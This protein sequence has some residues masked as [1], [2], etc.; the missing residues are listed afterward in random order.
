MTAFLDKKLPFCTRC[1]TKGLNCEY[2]E[3]FFKK[4][5]EKKEKKRRKKKGDI[6]TM[7]NVGDE[8][9]VAANAIKSIK[10]NTIETYC[11]IVCMGNPPFDQ[12][13]CLK[14]NNQII[15]NLLLGI[16]EVITCWTTRV[17]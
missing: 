11:S 5:A 13:V 7:F 2:K 14:S 15:Y 17:A 6:I 12:E 1:T 9:E 8:N 16:R 4:A 3:P 10:Q